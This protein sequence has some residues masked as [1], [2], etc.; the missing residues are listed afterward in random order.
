MNVPTELRLVLLGPADAG[1]KAAVC[2]LL[3]LQDNPQGSTDVQE[4]S[5]FSGEVCG[6]QVR[7]RATPVRELFLYLNPV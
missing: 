4:C 7:A 3:G 2:S 6:T 5:K 1:R